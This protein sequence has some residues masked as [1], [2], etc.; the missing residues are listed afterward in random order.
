MF[1]SDFYLSL[2]LVFFVNL[3]GHFA[4]GFRKPIAQAETY[5]KSYVFGSGS[6]VI[7]AGVWAWLANAWLYWLAFAAFVAA[8]GLGCIAGYAIDLYAN[9]STLRSADERD[10]D[11]AQN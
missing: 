1:N 6:I 10:R 11:H 4:P 8:A 9:F 5:V 2:A 3:A 7:C